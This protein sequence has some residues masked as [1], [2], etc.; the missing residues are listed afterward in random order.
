MPINPVLLTVGT[1]DGGATAIQADISGGVGT[2]AAVRVSLSTPYALAYPPGWPT[3]PGFDGA[4]L[5]SITGTIASGT[6]FSF[7]APEAAGL[8]SAGAANYA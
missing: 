7:L 1:I 4:A 2:A 8:V 6:T 3:R 5:A